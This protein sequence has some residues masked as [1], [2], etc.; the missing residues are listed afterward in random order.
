MCTLIH[1]KLDCSM[2]STLCLT[3]YLNSMT[4][5]MFNWYIMYMFI[6]ILFGWTSNNNITSLTITTQS[7]TNGSNLDII[8]SHKI[9]T[10][11]LFVRIYVNNDCDVFK[12]SLIWLVNAY[13]SKTFLQWNMQLPFFFRFIQSILLISHFKY[14]HFNNAFFTMKMLLLKLK[15]LKIKIKASYRETESA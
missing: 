3:L 14:S 8:Q 10:V 7:A 15:E 9:Q 2:C 13:L 12:F 11:T 5:H 6:V 4:C 1:C